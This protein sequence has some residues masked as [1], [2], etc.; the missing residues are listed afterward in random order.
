MQNQIK[1]NEKTT[2][3]KEQVVQA[4]I[5]N[6][7]LMLSLARIQLYSKDD[8][9][10]VVQEVIVS[11]LQSWRTFEG[12][13]TLKT[14]LLGIL[15]YKIIDQINKQKRSTKELTYQHFNDEELNDYE[16]FFTKEG[17]WNP[18]TFVNILCPAEILEQD[19][20]LAL[21]EFCLM[22]LPEQQSRIFLMREYL[23]MEVQEIAKSVSTSDGNLRVILHRCRLRLRDCA[24]KGWG[25]YI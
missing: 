15:K 18:E 8:A 12:R 20:L 22:K 7:H 21:V 6:H 10:D 1:N 4:C 23:G 14:W 13:S 5:E 24:V 11:A 25:E 16:N 19:Q 9:E 3:S 17:N 2:C